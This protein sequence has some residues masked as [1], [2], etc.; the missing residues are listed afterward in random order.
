MIRRRARP[1][2]AAPR[3]LDLTI[4]LTPRAGTAAAAAAST[5]VCTPAVTGLQWCLYTGAL[6][7][8]TSDGGTPPVYTMGLATETP[9]CSADDI[10]ITLSGGYVPSDQTGYYV[11]QLV[12]ETCGQPIEWSYAFSEDATP[13]WYDLLQPYVAGSVLI[14]PV[15]GSATYARGIAT[16]SA[17]IGGQSYGPITIT[18]ASA[19]P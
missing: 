9:V 16:I 8:L 7:T 12:G 11:F 15:Q 14:V 6:Y 3:P 1:A 17:T 2:P 4:T 10:A 5:G 13:T 18:L 19:Y